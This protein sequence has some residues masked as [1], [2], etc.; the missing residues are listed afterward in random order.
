MLDRFWGEADSLGFGRV[1]YRK[2]LC[3]VRLAFRTCPTVFTVEKRSLFCSTGSPLQAALCARLPSA[4]L[5][6]TDP[7]ILLQNPP[8]RVGKL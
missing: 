1:A 5:V 2:T 3:E 4:Q 7:R 6:L 8:S